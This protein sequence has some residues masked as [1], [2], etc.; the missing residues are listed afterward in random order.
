MALIFNV[1]LAC[2]ATV[3]DRFIVH[4]LAIQRFTEIFHPLRIKHHLGGPGNI[5][6]VQTRFKI[7]PMLFN[8]IKAIYRQPDHMNKFSRFE[9]AFQP[10]HSAN[11][12]GVAQAVLRNNRLQFILVGE[13]TFTVALHDI[14][15]IFFSH[16]NQ[17]CIHFRRQ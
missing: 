16:F 8:K 11:N 6:V 14:Q 5:L 10:F 4:S 12:A 9:R 17:G 2:P 7:Q 13:I 1:G 15:L 3:A